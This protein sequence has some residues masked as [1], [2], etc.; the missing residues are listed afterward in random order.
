MMYDYTVSLSTYLE[1]FIP[2]FSNFISKCPAHLD[3]KIVKETGMVSVVVLNE[4]NK[5]IDHMEFLINPLL[6]KKEQIRNVKIFLEKY[7]PIIHSVES[8]LYDK[9]EVDQLVESG[10]YSLVQALKL[11]KTVVTDL[12]Q[13]IRIHHRTNEIDCL[14]FKDKKTYKYKLH[15]PLELF[16]KK[17]WENNIETSKIFPSIS[18]LMYEVGNQN[19][20]TNIEN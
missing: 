1:D 2:T 8:V 6:E 5:V 4:Q 11:R 10:Q 7:Y 3:V 15:Q 9:E 18:K 14:N 16:M 20:K 19:E 17:M 13:I 12:Y